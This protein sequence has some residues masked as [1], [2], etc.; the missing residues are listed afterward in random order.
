MRPAFCPGTAF[1]LIVEALPICW[2]CEG[3]YVSFEI[4]DKSIREEGCG[5]GWSTH[6]SSSVRVING[7]HGYLET[8]RRIS[9]EFPTI[10]P[11]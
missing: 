11:M 10:A 4:I 2:C 1:R 8:K 3:K 7:V 6:I 9:F 5:E